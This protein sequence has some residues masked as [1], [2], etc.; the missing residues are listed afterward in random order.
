MASRLEDGVVF[1]QTK[2]KEVAASF[3]ITEE[4]VPALVLI[5]N[6]PEKVVHYG[7]SWYSF[8][9][10]EKHDHPG[11]GLKINSLFCQMGSLKVIYLS[12]LLLLISFLSS[13]LSVKT[14]PH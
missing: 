14:L 6:L 7:N 1:Y 11:R 5:K 4:T 3:H 9:F 8:P 2:S 12:T 10:R 13:F